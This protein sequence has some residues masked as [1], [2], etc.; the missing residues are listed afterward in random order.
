[1]SEP[2]TT[3]KPAPKKAYEVFD[4]NQRGEKPRKH[5]IIIKM[6]TDENGRIVGEPETTSYELRSDKGTKMTMEHAMKFLVDPAFK[7]V[8]PDGVR[9][10]Y[11][12][13]IDISKPVTHLGEDEVVVRYD[14]LSLEALQRR[15]KVLPGSEV[16][17]EDA[18]AE[19]YVAFL[20][21]WRA[22]LKGMTEGDRTLAEMI[23]SG[24]VASEQMSPEMLDR[25][26][27]KPDM[28][29]QAA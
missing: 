8:N 29:K 22:G 16:L 9:I 6:N 2:Q 17:P 1:M 11:V 15:V 12:P 28:L 26:F 3:A 19:E 7:V 18:K 25:M 5:D 13:K 24:A 10:P 4:M 14:E 23:A 27:G 21:K 20:K